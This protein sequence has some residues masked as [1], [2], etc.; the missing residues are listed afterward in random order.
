MLLF[1]DVPELA[2]DAKEKLGNRLLLLKIFAFL[3]SPKRMPKVFFLCTGNSCRS[4]MA[5]G[6]ARHFGKVE[7]CSAGLNLNP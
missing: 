2:K 1:T 6:W 3:Y 5:E 4:Q 7:P